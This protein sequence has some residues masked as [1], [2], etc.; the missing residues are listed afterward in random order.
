MK[1]IVVFGIVLVA[2]LI[3]LFA[4][5]QAPTE[6]ALLWKISGNGLSAPSYLYGTFHLL[7]E[8]DLQFSDSLKKTVASCKSVYL[9]L[10]MDDPNLP[11]EMAQGMTMTDGHTMKDYLSD[12]IYLATSAAFQSITNI[13]LDAVS[14]Y[15]PMLLLSMIY[16]SALECTPGS[17]ELEFIKLA[18]QNQV[19]VNGLETVQVQLNIFEKMPY[20]TQA[21][22]LSK[23]LL[24]MNLMKSE[25]NEMLELY[26]K[27]D[28]AGL[29]AFIE[30]TE[31]VDDEMQEVM[32]TNRNKSWIPK[33]VEASKKES[34][35]YAVGAG[36]LSGENGVINLLRKAGYT[37][38]PIFI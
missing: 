5:S 8:A 15:K 4:T 34:T 25:T 24:D 2:S 7:C 10:D 33:I 3:S 38:T 31:Y 35:F 17:P 9:E 14:N 22:E 30:K 20:S 32:L 27:K 11:A 18:G 1:K 12:S 28:I 16:P 23:Y 13:P 36:H 37:V 26:R 6:K 19:P 29:G 21:A